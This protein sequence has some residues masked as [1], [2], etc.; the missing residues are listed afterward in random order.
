MKEKKDWFHAALGILCGIMAALVVL[1]MSNYGAYAEALPSPT[2]VEH[3]R[4]DGDLELTGQDV[5][6]VVTDCLRVDV[7]CIRED[8]IWADLTLPYVPPSIRYVLLF[9][10]W[11][12]LHGEWEQTGEST[13][14]IHFPPGEK[15][16]GTVGLYLL[17]VAE[18]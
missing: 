9:D 15:M 3:L 1:A 18:K 17:I 7:T 14:R 6:L 8:G 12:L 16:D 2:A 11:H 4:L 5:D 13:L 10:G